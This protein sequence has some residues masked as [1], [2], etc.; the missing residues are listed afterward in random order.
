MEY[1][2]L[3]QSGLE[4]SRIGLGT[5]NFGVITDTK[6]SQRIMDTFY[7]LGGNFVD[8]ANVYRGGGVRAGLSEETLGKVLKEKRD[9]FVITTKGF[10]LME[11]KVWPNKVGFSRSYLSTEINNSLRRLQTEYIDLY[12]LHWY[13]PYTP[14]EE[15]MRVLDDFVRAG[16]IRYIGASNFEGWHIVKANEFARHFGLT[17]LIANQLWYNLV[18]RVIENSIVPACKEYNVSIISWGSLAEGFLTGRYK[19]GSAKPLEG[20]RLAGARE[21]ADPHT[22]KRIATERSWRTLEVM[23]R[24]AKGYNRSIANIAVRWL[25]QNGSCDVALIGASKIEHFQNNMQ[26][27]DFRLTEEEMRELTA[28]SEPEPLYPS[29]SY[30]AIVRKEGEFYGIG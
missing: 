10:F 13:D 5:S 6:T 20:T 30:K 8:T 12:L 18:D 19:R 17:P 15:T 21:G 28:V 22:W 26:V 25:L 7:D 29:S 16:K 24:L 14:L 2:Y 23:E 4:V 11:E 3:G 9:R 1:S 27:L